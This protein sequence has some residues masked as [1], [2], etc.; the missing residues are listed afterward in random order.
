MPKIQL[1]V[2]RNIYP[3]KD[4]EYEYQANC[5]SG[6]VF[7]NRTID[8]RPGFLFCSNDRTEWNEIKKTEGIFFDVIPHNVVLP[9]PPGHRVTGNTI[10]YVYPG[11]NIEIDLTVGI[12]GVRRTIILNKSMAVMGLNT[13]FGFEKPPGFSH[14]QKSKKLEFKDSGGVINAE[15]KTI[16]AWD[17]AQILSCCHLGRLC[18]GA[19][20][21]GCKKFCPASGK[22]PKSTPSLSPSQLPN[23]DLIGYD[24]SLEI[25]VALNWLISPDRIFPVF[26]N[27]EITSW[28]NVGS[29]TLAGKF[30]GGNASSTLYDSTTTHEN[31]VGGDCAI[32]DTASIAKVYD[33]D[34]IDLDLGASYNVDQIKVW[35]SGTAPV[36]GSS[37]KI[38]VQYWTGSAWVDFG[39]TD[40]LAYAPSVCETVVLEDFSAI[41]ARDTTKVRLNI[42]EDSSGEYWNLFINEIEVYGTGGGQIYEVSVGFGMQAGLQE[43]SKAE[44]SSGISLEMQSG[45]QESS[46]GEFSSAIS[47][48]MQS[49]LQELSKAEF[50]NAIQLGASLDL[51][52]SVI[53]EM[54]DALSLG[55]SV[56]LQRIVTK[57][58]SDG[59]D[60]DMSAGFQVSGQAIFLAAVQLGTQ[61]GYQAASQAEFQ[62]SVTFGNSLGISLSGGMH[63]EG[64]VSFGAQLGYSLAVLR[65]RFGSLTLDA[66]LDFQGISQL[67]A[68]SQINFGVSL[69]LTPTAQAIM[70]AAIAL[71]LQAGMAE[72]GQKGEFIEGQVNLDLKLAV[73]FAARFLWEEMKKPGGIW[74]ESDKPSDQWAETSKP[75]GTWK[76][77]DKPP[78]QWTETSKPPGI[79]KKKKT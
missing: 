51:Q 42:K 10:R 55:I 28:Q 62:D 40:E 9:N 50:S 72:A 79:W 20:R 2:D 33:T 44:F 47:L 8:G 38:K 7:F 56:D 58:V 30:D 34:T 49:G 66:S 22:C 36:G 35:V 48:G 68:Q 37:V 21:F 52:R 16:R 67:I 3:S 11:G 61:V 65:E 15:V 13:R 25:K 45:L 74:K 12:D 60:L 54:L 23:E 6:S 19:S 41:T 59:I 27:D 76:E 73:E 29:I 32:G 53:K 63:Y 78:D 24:D 43:S 64:A 17:S 31:G 77:S 70:N 39:G 75:S 46:K 57:E 26:I 1:D 5:K 18:Q 14:V 71:G 69:Q 4:P